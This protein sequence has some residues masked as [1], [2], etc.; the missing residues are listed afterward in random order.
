MI[1]SVAS[2]RST[3]AEPVL[4]LGRVKSELVFKGK[5]GSGQTSVGRMIR[6]EPN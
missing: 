2:A 1:S 6:E 5:Q 4:I 3:V